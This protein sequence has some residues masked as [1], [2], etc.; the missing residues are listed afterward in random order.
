MLQILSWSNYHHFRAN[1]PLTDQFTTFS[2]RI[3]SSSSYQWHPVST[4]VRSFQS[5]VISCSA[6]V[7]PHG[8]HRLSVYAFLYVLYQVFQDPPGT[9]S[10]QAL[11]DSS[12]LYPSHPPNPNPPRH[13]PPPHPLPATSLPPTPF[14]PPPA[15]L[16]LFPAVCRLL[17]KSGSGT[18]LSPRNS[19]SQATCGPPPLLL[20]W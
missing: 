5:C 17:L 15:S 16:C 4:P 20:A 7:C 9:S 3:A 8:Y 6:T 1:N 14:Y 2:W 13:I 19:G 18:R 11:T 10:E 12:T